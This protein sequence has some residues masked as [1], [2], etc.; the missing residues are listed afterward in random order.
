MNDNRSLKH[1]LFMTL[2]FQL[3]YLFKYNMTHDARFDDAAQRQCQKDLQL[4]EECN[5]HTDERGTGRLVSC[6]Y[7][8]LD[9]ITESACRY[10]I[11]QLQAVVFNDWRLV[12]YFSEACLPD[13]KKFE[14][15]RL[16]DENKKVT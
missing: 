11:N 2:E 4:L 13:I 16:D 8:R 14:C 5:A 10:F 3:I 15:G 9:N 12:E 7:D 1:A 6:L